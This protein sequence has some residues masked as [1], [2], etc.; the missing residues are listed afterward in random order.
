MWCGDGG[1]DGTAGH[2]ES[3]P[4]GRRLG[5][6]C[7]RGQMDGLMGRWREGSAAGERPGLQE[8]SQGEGTQGEEQRTGSW[9]LDS[10]DLANR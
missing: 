6:R 1:G 2:A 10:C 5:L 4:A 3:K 8:T 7:L 9:E